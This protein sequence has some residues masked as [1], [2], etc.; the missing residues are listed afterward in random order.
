MMDIELLCNEVFAGLSKPKARRSELVSYFQACVE[1]R[2][3]PTIVVATPSPSPTPLPST[4]PTADPALSS[5][6][7]RNPRASTIQAP[8]SANVG[9]T[10]KTRSRLGVSSTPSTKQRSPK[11]TAR[12]SNRLLHDQ[13]ADY[14]IRGLRAGRF[15]LRKTKARLQAWSEQGHETSRRSPVATRE[16]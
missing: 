5:R 3:E 4:P 8:V 13:L 11:R 9:S 10:A 15:C 16:Y 7:R 2:P 12:L 1:Y 14:E 6:P